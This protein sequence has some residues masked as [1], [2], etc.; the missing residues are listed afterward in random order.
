MARTIEYVIR[1]KDEN[2]NVISETEYSQECDIPTADEI[3][4]DSIEGFLNDFDKIESA[5]M[6]SR[7]NAEK[8]FIEAIIASEDKKKRENKTMQN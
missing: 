6:S 5:V 2:G 1:T 4:I 8:K 7:K 3:N